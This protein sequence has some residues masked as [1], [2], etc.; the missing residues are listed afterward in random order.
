MYNSLLHL[1]DKTF[2]SEILVNINK[3]LRTQLGVS[4]GATLYLGSLCTYVI[5]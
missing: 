2:K 3:F 4:S 1:L 5:T